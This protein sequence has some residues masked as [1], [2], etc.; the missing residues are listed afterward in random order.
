MR[1]RTASRRSLG[2][3]F[4]GGL[5]HLYGAHRQGARQAAA[6]M[7]TTTSPK[8][9]S[10]LRSGSETNLAQARRLER[11]FRAAGLTPKARHDT[12]MQGIMDANEAAVGQ[13]PDA[14]ARDL[15]N[16]AFGQ[17][18]AHFYL[19][20]YGTLRSYAELMGNRRVAGLLQET[21]DE[22]GAID[23]EFT[24]LAR[25]LSKR[26]SSPG[27]AGTGVV[28]TTAAM[29]PAATA[30]GIALAGALL[31]GLALAAFSASGGTRPSRRT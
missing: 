2:A 1:R 15:A 5:Q 4:E 27:Y 7:R 6:N 19:A 20:R 9:R 11:V 13:A 30:A 28:R 18:A 8:L 3:L 29:H 23:Q 17:L 16:I 22:T 21:L 31:G 24:R 14:A 10:M 25:Y 12:A 26:S